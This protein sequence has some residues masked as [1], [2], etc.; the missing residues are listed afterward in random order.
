MRFGICTGLDNCQEAVKA[1]ADYVECTV[2]GLNGKT[3]DELA[4][5][6]KALK[7]NN[8]QCEAMNVLF[9][10]NQIPL[11]GEKADLAAA[12]T[13]LNNTF[14]KICA[15][16]QP[17]VIV[18]GSGGARQV[19]EGFDRNKAMGQLAEAGQV[20]AKAAAPYGITIVLE[21][22]NRSECNIINSLAEAVDIAKRVNR[23][24]FKMLADFYHMLREDEPAAA[25][26]ECADWLSHTHIATR[27]GR[28]Y[29]QKEHAAMFAPYFEALRSIGYNERMSIE[30]SG[31]W[32]ALPAALEALRGW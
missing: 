5:L 24:N 32:E 21:P 3:E 13:Y 27:E 15:Y 1:G 18:F 4:A 20:I 16:I 7:E 25:L 23:P 8:I 30:A 19:P 22:L 17:K 29:P 2:T 26:H 11:T 31:E 28:L 9:P 10:G 14:K 12:E 6:V